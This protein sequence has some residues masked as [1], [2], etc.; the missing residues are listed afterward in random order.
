MIESLSLKHR[1]LNAFIGLLTGGIFFL[2][3]LFLLIMISVSISARFGF[4]TNMDEFLAG[5]VCFLPSELIS[6]VGGII[7]GEIGN[8]HNHKYR[9]AMLGGLFGPFSTLI[10]LSITILN[11]W[12][13][14]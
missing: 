11:S 8:K 6:I 5:Y 7:G 4:N 3:V 14:H 9:G 1:M 13:T 10:P 2:P 12:A